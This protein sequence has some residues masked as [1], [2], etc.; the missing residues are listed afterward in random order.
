MSGEVLARTG[1]V[2]PL[3]RSPSDQPLTQSYCQRGAR[4]LEFSCADVTQRSA[5]KK[6]NNG[7][8]THLGA[9]QVLVFLQEFIG[10]LD[11]H[12]IVAIIKVIWVGEVGGHGRL[13]HRDRRQF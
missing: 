7:R 6:G 11:R 9:V 13:G 2:T 12:F 5:N 3:V 1:A 8:V 10:L 4:S